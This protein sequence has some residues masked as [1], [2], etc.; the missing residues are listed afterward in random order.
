MKPVRHRVPAAMLFCL[1]GAFLFQQ[2]CGLKPTVL[3]NLLDTPENHVSSGFKLIEKNYLD[4]ARREFEL[5]LRLDSRYS[6]A[7]RGLG[8]V[9]GKTGSYDRAF[10]A[11]EKARECARHKEEE[12]M[13]YLGIMSLFQSQK[14]E[15]WLEHMEDQF[16]SILLIREKLPEAYFRMGVAYRQ[17]ERYGAA[18][19]AF[20]AVQG[21]N[22]G[23]VKEAGEELMKLEQ[24]RPT[25][26]GNP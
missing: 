24:I 15:G 4:D 10:E 26:G 12:A 17:A 11:M 2:G 14:A 25:T 1:V 16:I 6:P 18:E 21:F 8:F 19:R 20:K 13:A 22:M 9:Y 7:Y 5:A 3:E 23:Y